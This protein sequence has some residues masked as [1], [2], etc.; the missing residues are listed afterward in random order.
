MALKNNQS[1]IF[2]V[3][4]S[5]VAIAMGVSWMHDA[6]I[7]ERVITLRYLMLGAAGFISFVTPYLLFPDSKSKLIQLGNISGRKLISYLFN[8]TFSYYIYFYLFI[9][10][11]LF[12]DSLSAGSELI[13][14]SA[15]SVYAL[16]FITGLHCIALYLY[17]KVGP[18]SQFWQESEKGRELR[19]K[20]ANYFKYPMDPGAIPSL[21]NTVVLALFGM[22]FVI[23]GTV[24]GNSV[25]FIAEAA[26]SL[27]VFLIGGIVYIAR[28]SKPE[29]KYYHT[30]SF[31]SEFFGASEG[32][33]TITARR[34]VDQ[35][36]WVPSPI[37]VNVWQYLQQ[38]DRKIPAGRAVAAGHVLVW[39]VA[40]QKPDINFMVGIWTLFAVTHHLFI[41]LTMQRNFSPHWMLR[42]LSP[43]KSWVF[44]WFWMQVRWLLP[45]VISMNAQLFVFGVPRG[46][47]QLFVIVVYLISAMAVA[48]VGGFRLKKS[49]L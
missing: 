5:V 28:N 23:I 27:I 46:S 19:F 20:L 35:L 36:W 47:D 4:I 6:A 7:E 14:K 8:R 48:S 17:L 12:A 10:A 1:L 24:V 40:Y 44:S 34:E 15:Y 9:L 32:E 33:D 42:W 25:G 26:F 37:R 43:I 31:F 3:F 22:L 49:I 11:T 16:L 18:Q 45:L 2:K 30:N 21:V 29:R 41:L 38:I 39:L 13:I